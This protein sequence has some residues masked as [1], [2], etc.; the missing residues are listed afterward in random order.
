M[1]STPRAAAPQTT[2]ITKPGNAIQ[3]TGSN[4]PSSGRYEICRSVD[5]ATALTGDDVMM[6][7]IRGGKRT[8]EPSYLTELLDMVSGTGGRISAVCK[9]RCEDLRATHGR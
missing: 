2:C 5:T 9:L 1:T 8:A 6:R 4:Q 7:V 3:R